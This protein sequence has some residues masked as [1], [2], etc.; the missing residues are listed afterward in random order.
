MARPFR[1]V[2][3]TL[4]LAVAVVTCLPL[5]A[6][7]AFDSLYVFG[8]SLSD[9]GNVQAVTSGLAPLVPPTP[10]PYYFNGRYSNGPNFAETLA[11][12]LGLGPVVPSVLGG[13]D[14][15][16]GGA[17]ATGTPPP[18]SVVVQDIDDQVALYLAAHPVAS[19]TALYVVYAGSN[20]L[21]TNPA[22]GP[23]A[24]ASLAGSIDRLYDAGAR[25]VLVPNLPLLGLV[26]RVNGDPAARAAAD[27]ATQQ[28]NTALAA[29]LD[30]LGAS[31]PGLTLYRLDVAGLFA[32][33]VA[34]PAGFGLTNVTA[35]AAPG[36]HVGDQSYNTS[37]IVPNPD[38][39]L[40]WDDLHPTRAGHALLGQA[41]LAAVPEPSLLMPVAL[42]VFGLLARRRCVTSG[43]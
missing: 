32:D 22:G 12:G 11:G 18:T 19:P 9:V 17:L 16:Y 28:F 41:A 36:L 27:A 21:I 4:V 2:A 6:R 26:P 34:N 42:G 23:A 7:G 43:L 14:Y 13:N 39:Y 8:D 24:A 10:G 25:H 20:D 40:F 30:S 35:S 1:N 15:A 37:L 38:Q 29:S 3:S 31:D 33:I 5:P